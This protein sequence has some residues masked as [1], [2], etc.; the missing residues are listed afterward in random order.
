MPAATPAEFL[1]EMSL[2]TLNAHTRFQ[3]A[4]QHAQERLARDL[5]EIVARAELAIRAVKES[6]PSP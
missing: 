5:D 3:A 4:V 1:R 6:S 2:Q